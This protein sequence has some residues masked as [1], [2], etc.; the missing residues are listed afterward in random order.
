MLKAPPLVQLDPSYSSVAV[1]LPGGAYPP[2][3]TPAVKTPEEPKFLLAVVTFP[4]DVQLDPS[5]SSDEFNTVPGFDV[6]P[7]ALTAEV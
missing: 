7:A 6:R 2:N 3:I 5:Y 4:P 1:V